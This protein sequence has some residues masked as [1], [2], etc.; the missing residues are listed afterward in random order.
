MSRVTA[1][2]LLVAK[3]FSIFGF[4][5]VFKSSRE[6]TRVREKKE[7]AWMF[8]RFYQRFRHR[9]FIFWLWISILICQSS[10]VLLSVLSHFQNQSWEITVFNAPHT[11]QK[12]QHSVK[13]SFWHFYFAVCFDCLRCDNR[14][15]DYMHTHHQNKWYFYTK[16][17]TEHKKRRKW[18]T[19]YC[20][21]HLTGKLCLTFDAA[22]LNNCNKRNSSN[23]PLVYLCV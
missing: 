17:H 8:V 20:V 22:C 2:T 21:W 1:M 4:V 6:P 5:V 12:K 3:C 23:S 10:I 15:R 11:I 18:H 19:G 13:Q 7:S 16:Q 14:N 9:L